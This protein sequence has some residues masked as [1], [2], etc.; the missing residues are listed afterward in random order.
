VPLRQS[1]PWSAP[2]GARMPPARINLGE[3]PLRPLPFVERVELFHHDHDRGVALLIQGKGA[4]G[5]RV[6]LNMGMGPDGIRTIR[7]AAT[8]AASAAC[9]SCYGIPREM[10]AAICMGVGRDPNRFRLGRHRVCP[11]ARG[12]CRLRHS[13]GRR[14]DRSTCGLARGECA[15]RQNAASLPLT[16]QSA[17]NT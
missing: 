9:H 1:V 6:R 3:S 8:S 16:P 7:L 13:N 14:S 12:N 17:G 15:Q 4:H 5:R 10:R 11:L 2:W